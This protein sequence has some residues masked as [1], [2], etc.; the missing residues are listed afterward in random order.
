MEERL[1]V[2]ER[3]KLI[4]TD[5]TNCD[6]Y[7][8]QQQTNI[9]KNKVAKIVKEIGFDVSIFFNYERLPLRTL[10]TFNHHLRKISTDSKVPLVDVLLYFEE[11]YTTVQRIKTL[12]DEENVQIIKNELSEKYAIEIPVT[13]SKFIREKKKDGL[14]IEG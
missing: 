4:M 2:E 1:Y 11:N 12:L 7:E 5:S 8:N 14:P 3:P 6:Y 9:N 13:L 10:Y